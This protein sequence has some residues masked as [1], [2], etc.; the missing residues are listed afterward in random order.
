MPLG[1]ELEP[2][3]FIVFFCRRNRLVLKE[4]LCGILITAKYWDWLPWRNT[5]EKHNIFTKTFFALNL[6]LLS[7]LTSPVGRPSS[8]IASLFLFLSDNTIETWWKEW[9]RMRSHKLIICF[10]SSCYDQA[11]KIPTKEKS[12]WW[13]ALAC[14]GFIWKKQQQQSETMSLFSTRFHKFNLQNWSVA[15]KKYSVN[16]I[17]GKIHINL[18]WLFKLI[19]AVFKN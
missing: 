1:H 13:I 5:V 4:P 7:K 12:C 3:C 18:K 14:K 8:F 15:S 19:P 16:L 6:F 17:T 2:I 9:R 10:P 11:Q